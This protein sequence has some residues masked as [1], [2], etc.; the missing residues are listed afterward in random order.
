MMSLANTSEL[1]NLERLDWERVKDQSKEM[2]RGAILTM[3]TAELSLKLALEEL[4]KYE[5]Q[6]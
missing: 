1:V 2:I 6:E 5:S 4:K 3:R